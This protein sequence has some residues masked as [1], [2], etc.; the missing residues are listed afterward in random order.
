MLAQGCSGPDAEPAN[1]APSSAVNQGD[2][3]TRT[4]LP[5]QSLP[6]ATSSTTAPSGWCSPPGGLTGDFLVVG[7]LPEY[8]AFNPAWGNCLTDF[9]Y[10]SAEPSPDGSLDTSRFDPL[11]LQRMQ[12]MKSRYGTR[13]HISLGGYNRSEHFG[14]VVTNP[15]MRRV[16]IAELLK[17]AAAHSLDGIDFDWEFPETA[18]QQE[19]YLLL[20]KEVEQ[21]GL[22]VSVAL[23]PYSDRDLTPYLGID[24]IHIMSYDRGPSHSTYDQSV[25]DLDLFLQ[26]GFS[27]RQLI[28]GVPFYGRRTTGPFTSFPYSE[29]AAKYAPPPETDEV[30]GIFFNGISTIQ[31]KVCYARR[32]DFGGVMIWELGQDSADE[33]SLLRA[34]HSRLVDGCPQ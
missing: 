25:A 17:F 8:R 30:D 20:M 13:L 29:I 34:I 27:R 32:K 24:R 4:H 10:F 33:S 21:A 28:L 31:K 2:T 23:Y 12:E 1:P 5:D 22:I 18:A 9:I 6:P 11:A 26:A 19:G 14:A 15:R 7:Y 3:A 16:L